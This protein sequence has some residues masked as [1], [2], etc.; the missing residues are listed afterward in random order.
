VSACPACRAPSAGVAEAL[1]GGAAY[2]RCG[3]CGVEWADPLPDGVPV[4]VDFTDAG[5]VMFDE[6]RAGSPLAEML[7]PNEALLLAALGRDVKPGGTVLE[8]CCESG[9][10]LAA[11]RDAG[12]QPLGADPLPRPAPMLREQGFEV[13]QGGP[14]EVP[15]EWQP[16]AVVMLESLVRFP[17]PVG[18]L[19]EV[20]ARFPR[21]VVHLAVS[22]P[23]QSLKLPENDRRHNYP[24]HHLVRWTERGV[25]AALERAGYRARTRTTRAWLNWPRRRGAFGNTLALVLRLAGQAEYSFLAAGTPR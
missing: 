14:A 1:D 17:D 2:L 19:A 5:R 4:F 25:A 6:L 3:A 24:P 10:F 8:L 20:R 11:L 9:R 13:V 18:L 7:T 22:S 15:A 23:R 21:A 12:F 16:D